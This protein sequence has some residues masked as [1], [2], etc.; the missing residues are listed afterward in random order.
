VDGFQPFSEWGLKENECASQCDEE[1]GEV[2]I[3][4]VF[5]FVREQFRLWARSSGAFMLDLSWASYAAER[6]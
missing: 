2:M 4:L 6:P 5:F 1:T 3:E